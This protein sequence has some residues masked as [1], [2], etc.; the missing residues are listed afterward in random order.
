MNT[1]KPTLKFQLDIVDYQ[2]DDAIIESV[3]NLLKLSRD[4]EFIDSVFWESGEQVSA[5]P[6]SNISIL[7]SGCDCK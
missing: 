6:N 2:D 1:T 3:R 7:I 5:K 4:Q